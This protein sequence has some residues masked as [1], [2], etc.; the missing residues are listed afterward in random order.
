M[1]ISYIWYAYIYTLIR[2][3]QTISWWEKTQIEAATQRTRACVCVC[4]CVRSSARVCVCMYVCAYVHACA[5]VCV[6]VCVRWCVCVYD[7]YWQSSWINGP[8]VR[9]RVRADFKCRVCPDQA[10]SV[11]VWWSGPR[12]EQWSGERCFSE[13]HY[14]VHWVQRD[15]TKQTEDLRPFPAPDRVRMIFETR[16]I[17]EHRK[18]MRRSKKPVK[19]FAVHQVHL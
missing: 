11:Q 3:V 7:R 6:C 4:V 19:H 16:S 1:H 8:D 12:N 2:I 9:P 10:M 13:T 17:H 14:T 15:C 5:C 18:S